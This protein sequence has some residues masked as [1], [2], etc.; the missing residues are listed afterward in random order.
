MIPGFEL[1]TGE[2]NMRKLVVV[3]LALAMVVG[4]FLA[5]SA[6]VTAAGPKG[7]YADRL[8]FF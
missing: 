8:V 5:L 7:G 1:W 6:S 4:A 2:A 3:F